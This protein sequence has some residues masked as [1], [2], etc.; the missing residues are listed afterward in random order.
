M[1]SSSVRQLARVTTN[2]PTDRSKNP[3]RGPSLNRAAQL[4]QLIYAARPFWLPQS[5]AWGIMA[6][7]ALTDED[8]SELLL[9][10]PALVA[11][12]SPM[13]ITAPYIG[14]DLRIVARLN[15]AHD[16]DPET[17]GHLVSEMAEDYAPMHV[18][19][20]TVGILRY[21]AALTKGEPGFEQEPLFDYQ[22]TGAVLSPLPDGSLSNA[23]IWVLRRINPSIG[24][25]TTQV[26]QGQGL[27]V[28]GSSGTFSLVEGRLD[29]SLLRPIAEALAAVVAWGSW[30]AP[31]PFE[32]P[33]T[34][35]AGF[36]KISRKSAVKKAESR[37]QIA[38]VHVL[39]AR[40]PSVKYSTE[41]NSSGRTVA[42]HY[43][44][45]HWQRYRVG[46]RSNWS[47]ERRRKQPV[48][49]NAGAPD[50]LDNQVRIYRLPSPPSA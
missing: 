7:K 12:S 40:E 14:A 50:D 24:A 23:V 28:T 10:C 8:R 37:G 1:R 20:G 9:P 41:A 30:T 33:V 39:A 21:Y 25:T 6:T 34:V 22:L 42:P 18:R 48:I 35:G 13:E 5:T 2:T 3:N 31:D 19:S 45:G 38:G 44:V 15:D 17:P 46:P 27:T 49:V 11:F 4:T 36:R 29:R 16:L 32:I 47:Y 26:M 43:R